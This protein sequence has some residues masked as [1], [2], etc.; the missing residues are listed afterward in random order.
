MLCY[1]DLPS[2]LLDTKGELINK[3][4]HQTQDSSLL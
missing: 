4:T 2:E 1:R 3:T